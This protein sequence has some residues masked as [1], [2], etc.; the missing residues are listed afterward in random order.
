MNTMDILSNVLPEKFLERLQRLYS[1]IELQ[2]ILT[3]L[4]TK[5][6]PSFRTNTLKIT[7]KELKITLENQ[8]FIIE[9]VAWYHDAFML[10]NKS[11]R[12]LTE[13]EEYKKG[14]I[15]IQNLSS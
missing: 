14:Y 10:Q 2:Q 15:Y 6:L 5:P 13:T 3:V 1:E 7:T 12:E 4:Q 9:Q 11:I 8:G